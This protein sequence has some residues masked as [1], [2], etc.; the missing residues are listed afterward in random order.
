VSLILPC[1]TLLGLA[2]LL[3]Q[4]GVALRF[5]LH[6]RTATA[7]AIPSVTVL[8]PL[9][10][11]DA[12]TAAC[13]RS[14]LAQSYPAPVQFLFGVASPEDPA[15]DL[16]R[17]LLAQHPS[18]DAQLAICPKSLGPNAK[19]STLVQLEPSIRHECLVISDADVRVP[20]DLLR[21]VVAPLA[22]A[23][24]G[25]VNCFYQ[26]ANPVNV[27]MRWEAFAINADFWSQ[28]LQSRSLRP[29]DFALGAVMA[30]TRAHLNRIGGF[31][32]LLN[33]LADD[34]Q[35]GHRVAATGAR[36]E[37]CPVVVECWNAP[38]NW[39]EVWTHQLRWARTIRV[40]QP[41]PYFFSILSNATL[42][43]VLWLLASL[44]A[45]AFGG[46]PSGPSAARSGQPWATDLRWPLAVG[47]FVVLVR[48]L[49]GLHLAA[50]LTRSRRHVPYFWL[51]P[52][53]DLLQFFVW[54]L[55]FVGNRVRWRGETFQVKAGGELVKA[56]PATPIRK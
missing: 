49:T 28:V 27:A 56:N 55:A 39:A 8:K 17:A 38:M 15:C 11:C 24:V 19:V 50:R 3:W 54:A 6:R 23:E 25:L 33:H 43:P 10:G 36:I 30:T 29:L 41:A 13:L 45:A 42:W 4:W 37:L 14:W 53:K 35:L 12:E 9:K 22:A 46:G 52:L 32:T 26:L 2:L 34:Y 16:V 40:C 44:A 1:L 5:P 7:H 51:A 48:M 47:A 20:P 31:A 21:E 18:A